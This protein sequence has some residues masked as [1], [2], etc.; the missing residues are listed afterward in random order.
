MKPFYLTSLC[1]R[2]RLDYSCLRK[3]NGSSEPLDVAKVRNIGISAHIDSGKT[4]ISERIL[5]YTNRISSMHEGNDDSL[6]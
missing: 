5:F 1:K 2:V 6:E 3:L 4:T